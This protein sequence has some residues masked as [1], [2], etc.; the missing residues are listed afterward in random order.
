MAWVANLLVLA[1]AAIYDAAVVR[2]VRFSDWHTAALGYT[3]GN[4]TKA[5]LLDSVGHEI[6]AD[7]SSK[8]RLRPALG[9]FR[10]YVSGRGCAELETCND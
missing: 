7:M 5:V 2:K 1:A 10:F 3:D 8:K 9:T 4:P 6:P